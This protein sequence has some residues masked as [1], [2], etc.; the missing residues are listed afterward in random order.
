MNYLLG[1]SGLFPFLQHFHKK[2]RERGQNAHRNQYPANGSTE[3]DADIIAGQSKAAAQAAFPYRP[4]NQRQYHRRCIQIQFP[5][6]IAE[7]AEQEHNA[8]FH[9]TVVNGKR[10][11]HAQYEYAG[12]QDGVGQAGDVREQ[13]AAPKPIINMKNCVTT[14][15]A[16]NV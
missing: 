11:Y 15:P 1:L 7:K 16:K 3:K 9:K 4:Q 2:W 5:H 14:K 8:H 13:T 12:N 6:Q 10:T